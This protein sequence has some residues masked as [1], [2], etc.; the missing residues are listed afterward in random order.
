MTISDPL[1]PRAV[2]APRIFISHSAHEPEA[3]ELLDEIADGLK[4]AGFVVL[5]DRE[6]LAP[7]SEWRQEIYTWMGL[8]HGAVV[9]L[10][11]SALR[12]ESW[13]S[14]EATLLR[15]RKALDPGMELVP[16]LL[17]P[18][19]HQKLKRGPL[20]RI[21]I[22]EIHAAPND[23]NA[24]V[25]SLTKRFAPLLRPSAALP[26]TTLEAWVK[27]I[28]RALA[29]AEHSNPDASGEAAAA[30]GKQLP[31]WEPYVTTRERLAREM[32]GWEWDP[33]RLAVEYLCC[34]IEVTP[35]ERMI[36]ILGCLW[37]NPQDVAR[38]PEVATGPEPGRVIVL[39][40]A[41][42]WTAQ[43]YIRRAACRVPNWIVL[44]A[45]D[46]SGEGQAARISQ[47]IRAA[48]IER[49]SFKDGYTSTQIN[50]WLRDS[51][52]HPVVILLDAEGLD[53]EIIA[54]VRAEWPVPTLLLLTGGRALAPEIGTAGNAAMLMLPDLDSAIEDAAQDSYRVLKTYLKKDIC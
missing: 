21:A 47:E 39:N 6:R 49:F 40:A 10:S 16:V 42:E 22:N 24:L 53:L 50:S 51:W 33:I 28:A 26:G 30:A 7:G 25:G 41:A 44:T 11:A 34:S 48:M 20:G 8:C 32:L 5:L 19:T 52:E 12:R 23:A 37:V 3:R 13:V 4:K 15:W 43:M 54:A 1:A 9:L 27:V 45:A 2:P 29:D 46:H 17:P 35:L 14:T 31:A 18:V 38:I 36:Q